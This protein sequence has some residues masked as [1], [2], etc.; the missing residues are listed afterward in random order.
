MT[1]VGGCRHSTEP[2]RLA[3]AG[4]D[5]LPAL[6]LCIQLFMTPKSTTSGRTLLAFHYLVKHPRLIAVTSLL[7]HAMMGSFCSLCFLSAPLSSRKTWTCHHFQCLSRTESQQWWEMLGLPWLLLSSYSDSRV[8][9][10]AFL[11]AFLCSCGINSVI[12]ACFLFTEENLRC[13]GDWEEEDYHFIVLSG[14]GIETRA[15]YVLV[16]Q[17]QWH[18]FSFAK[19]SEITVR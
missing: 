18:C 14:T 16:R 6:A 1:V 15:Q 3:P 11:I 13:W 5:H 10:H 19:V 17:Q 8:P 12:T 7:D 4:D 9:L 2:L